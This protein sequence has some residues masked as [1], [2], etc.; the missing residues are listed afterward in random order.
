MAYDPLV[1]ADLVGDALDLSNAEVSDLVQAV[2]FLNVLPLEKSSNGETHKY[3]KETGAPVVGFRTPNAGRDEDSSVDTV[4]TV[5]LKV[6]DFS[7]SVDK[8]VADIWRRGGAAALIA[9]EGMRHLKAALVAFEKQVIYG[10]SAKGD[11]AGFSGMINAS[12]VDALADALTIDAGGTT[13]DTATSC[14]AVRVG[15]NDLMGVVNGD[16]EIDL[17]ETIVQRVAD[18]SGLTYPAYYTP[19][20]TWLGLQV[21]SVYSMGRIVNITEDSTKTLT[22]DLI[23]RLLAEF[24]TGFEPT[25]LLMNRRSLR[26]LQDSRTATNSTGAPAP[27]PTEAFGVPIVKCESI[28]N[29]EALVA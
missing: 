15:P 5:T 27:F 11:S 12:T 7:F 13:A 16:G 25:H 22:D 19:G 2:P 10:T 17:G 1:M 26:Q 14:W 21:G 18:G 24:P 20:C 8:A 29:T 9:R 4:A 6:L 28:V 3:V 23:A